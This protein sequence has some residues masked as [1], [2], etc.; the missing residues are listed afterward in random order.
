V[1]VFNNRMFR[2]AVLQI[3]TVTCDEDLKSPHGDPL[4]RS[5]ELYHRQEARSKRGRVAY[6]VPAKFEFLDSPTL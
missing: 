6:R 5:T 2:M 1:V 4:Q 3:V